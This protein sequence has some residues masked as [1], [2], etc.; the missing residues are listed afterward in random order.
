MMVIENN[1]N[2][3][4]VWEMY[5]EGGEENGLKSQNLRERAFGERDAWRERG[6]GGDE[7]GGR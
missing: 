2:V 3:G 5:V 1:N 4:D 7:S 6:F